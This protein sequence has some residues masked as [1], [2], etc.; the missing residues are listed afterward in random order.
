M[1]LNIEDCLTEK[2]EEKKGDKEEGEVKEEQKRSHS[3][4]TRG[5][6]L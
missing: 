2:E 3:K 1:D 5:D 6:Q 4:L